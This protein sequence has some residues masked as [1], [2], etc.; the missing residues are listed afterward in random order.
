MDPQE[1]LM[2]IM[3]GLD[4]IR[5]QDEGYPGGWTRDQVYH[6]ILD[7]AR[8]IKYGGFAPDLR[9]ILAALS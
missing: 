5:E 7:L 1:T 8:W 9:K 3:E 6:R 2:E 4:D